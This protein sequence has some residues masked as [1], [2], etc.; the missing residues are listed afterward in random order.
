MPQLRYNQEEC[1]CSICSL[2]PLGYDIVHRHTARAHRERDAL[3]LETL[4]GTSVNQ[5]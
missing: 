3:Q 4:D 5:K 1:R 2:K